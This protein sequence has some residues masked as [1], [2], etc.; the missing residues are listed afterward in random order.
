M[1]NHVHHKIPVSRGGTDDEWNL[2]ELDPYTHAYEHALDFVLFDSAPMVDFRQQGWRMIPQDL[3]EK[4][5]E[6]H[7]SRMSGDWNPTATGVSLETRRKQS[8][9]RRGIP[10]SADHR[11]KIRQSNLN[12]TSIACPHCDKIGREAQMKRWHFD[13]CRHFTGRIVPQPR[14]ICPYCGINGS[15]CNLKRYHFDNCKKK[16]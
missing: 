11:E 13:N 6:K 8:D 3:R 4:V 5:L 12:H 16:K 9:I 10:K 1:A 15:I 2:V 14:T 7:R